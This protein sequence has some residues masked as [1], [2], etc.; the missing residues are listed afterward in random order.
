ML[1]QFARLYRVSY[2]VLP[3]TS[4]RMRSSRVSSSTRRSG[5]PARVSPGARVRALPRGERVT[6]LVPAWILEM[7]DSAPRAALRKVVDLPGWHANDPW[8]LRLR[9]PA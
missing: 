9:K 4:T 6:W 1:A 3:A 8:E 5:H 7:A 2:D